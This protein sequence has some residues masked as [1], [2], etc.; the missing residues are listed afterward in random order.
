MSEITRVDASPYPF[1]RSPVST[2]AQEASG[3]VLPYQAPDVAARP[4]V[5]SHKEVEEKSDA[6]AETSERLRAA[7][8]QM[9]DY[10][11]STQRDLHFSYDH[12]SGETVVKV[13]DRKT[14]D[15][16]R[17]IPD[18]IFLKISQA[19]DSQGDIHLINARA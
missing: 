19:I 6:H 18:Q 11:Q 16:I 12:E 4:V 13:V 10:I 1:S 2:D 3:K 5:V 8:A 14:Q 17:Q 15:V 7:V 9:N